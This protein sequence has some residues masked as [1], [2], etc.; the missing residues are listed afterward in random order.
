MDRIYLVKF[1]E[2]NRI[3]SFRCSVS[4]RSIFYI[5]ILACFSEIDGVSNTIATSFLLFM[6]IALFLVVRRFSIYISRVTVF[7]RYCVN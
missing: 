7:D 3:H 4:H 1:L 6:S 2:L 5:I